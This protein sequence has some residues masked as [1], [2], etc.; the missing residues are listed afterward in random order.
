MTNPPLV[1]DTN[2]VLDLFVFDDEGARALRQA[3]G[4]DCGGAPLWLAS[5][6]MRDELARVLRY[7]QIERRLRSRELAPG[8][9]LQ[10]FDRH[11]RVVPGA[12]RAVF[13]C[14][15]PDDQ[16]FV[17]LAVAHRAVLLSK[18]QA[19]LA[20]RRRLLTLGVEVARNW[21]AA[22]RTA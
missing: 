19:V 16:G 12:A 2:I 15:D 21:P 22:P 7:P 1:L 20:M 6:A 11:A 4:A 13:V 3:F 10:A 18:D 9:V 17:D 14:K 5:T 8:A